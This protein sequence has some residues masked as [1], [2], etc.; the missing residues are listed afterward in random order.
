MKFKSKVFYTNLYHKNF[1]HKTIGIKWNKTLG[2]ILTNHEFVDGLFFF[3]SK[4]NN[5]RY[6]ILMNRRNKSLIL[7]KTALFC[8]RLI[9]P[10]EK[11]RIKNK[12]SWHT[13]TK[14]K[15]AIKLFSH[16]LVKWNVRIFFFFS[17]ITIEM[18]MLL[19]SYQSH[20]RINFK[21]KF[22]R[23]NVIWSL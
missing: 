11:S 2:D 9:F 14:N 4:L 12:T 1:S 21:N 22:K 20:I 17:F 16:H 7:L 23:V 13:P 15:N 10:D 5:R 3:L 6:H 8:K 19:K 18:N